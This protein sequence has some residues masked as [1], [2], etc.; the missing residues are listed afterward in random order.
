MSMR[1]KQ[2]LAGKEKSKNARVKA[3]RKFAGRAVNTVETAKDLARKKS[4]A[5]KDSV[6]RAT[7]KFAS[8][9]EK[10]VE[11]IK[12][13]AQTKAGN[14]KDSAVRTVHKAQNA[15]DDANRKATGV[16]KDIKDGF[17]ELTQDIHETAKNISK[18]V[19]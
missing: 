19:K 15:I 1:D 4:D 2:H 11:T 9:A 16:K 7:Q 5:V 18:S 8:N 3:A 17:H 12:D 10:T 14:L 13:S 6:I